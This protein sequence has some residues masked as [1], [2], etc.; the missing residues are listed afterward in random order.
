MSTRL[1]YLVKVAIACVTIMLSFV[2]MVLLGVLAIYLGYGTFESEYNSSA[3]PLFLLVW[4][5]P[6]FLLASVILGVVVGYR[7]ELP[8]TRLTTKNQ[9][10]PLPKSN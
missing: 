9:N 8:Q 6:L 4:A 1:K 10:Q 2:A 3:S 7:M 5:S